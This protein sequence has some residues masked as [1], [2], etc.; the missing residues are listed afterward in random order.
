MA[1]YTRK[2][3]DAKEGTHGMESGYVR[4]EGKQGD[5]VTHDYEGILIAL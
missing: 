5:V 3:S 4:E 2:M 1:S